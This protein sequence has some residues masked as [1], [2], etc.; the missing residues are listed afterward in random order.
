MQGTPRPLQQ[1]PQR[2]PVQHLD[3]NALSVT[4]AL[5]VASLA[6]ILPADHLAAWEALTPINAADQGVTAITR[7][8]LVDATKAFPI[9]KSLI[10]PNQTRL[11]EEKKD[12]PE[13]LKPYLSSRRQLTK[14]EGVIRSGD[15]TITPANL[16]QEDL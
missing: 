14:T 6:V 4:V 9:C 2:P 3:K 5:T 16:S 15:R 10:K 7:P 1:Q 8:K 13:Q 12:W 11:P